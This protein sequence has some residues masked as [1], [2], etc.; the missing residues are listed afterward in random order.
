MTMAKPMIVNHDGD[1]DDDG[2]TCGSK[3][4]MT[5]DDHDVNAGFIY[6]PN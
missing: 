3:I 5:D 2:C 6:N 4:T 1:D